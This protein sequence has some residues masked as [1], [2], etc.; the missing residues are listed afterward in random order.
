MR[1]VHVLPRGMH[2]G[3]RRATAIDL[4]AR[5]FVSHSQYANSTTV[6]GAP[7]EAPFEDV[8]FKP[9]QLRAGASHLSSA[10]RFV[11]AARALSPDL[12]IVHHHVLSGAVIG[13]ALSPLPVVLHRHNLQKSGNF[14]MRAYLRWQYSQFART[15]WVSEV[16]RQS[17]LAVLPDFAASSATLHSGLDLTAWTPDR[18]RE[19]VVLCVGRATPDKGMLEA[20]QALSAT[21]AQLPDWRARF[22]LSRLDRKDDYLDAVREALVPLGSR[23]E[24]QTDQP[25]SVVK[26]AYKSAAIAM[27]PSVFPEP[28]GRTAIEAFAGGAA[29]I[30]SRSGGLS[31]VVGDA[32]LTL[33]RVTPEAISRA[34]GSLIADAGLR[35]DY[36][37][38]GR[39]RAEQCFEIRAQSRELDRICASV[40]DA[41]S[42]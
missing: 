40:L 6:L 4:C 7:V 1:I 15:T 2:F 16:A 25:H 33:D 39:R 36:A 29:L 41:R 21:L 19:Q 5:D 11:R 31:E 22:V 10:L 38:R 27:V 30:A 42:R 37:A 17:F 24:I 35:A 14:L 34:L 13:R 3:P 12:V 20:A 28:F 23:A 8:K 18:D 26:R 32:A 9:V